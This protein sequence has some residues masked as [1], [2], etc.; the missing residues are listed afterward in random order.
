MNLASVQNRY[1]RKNPV[2]TSLKRALLG[3]ALVMTIV[4]SAF[5]QATEKAC[6][7]VPRD[8]ERMLPPWQHG[9]NNDAVKRGLE[10]T[11]PQV[12]VLADFHGDPTTPKLVLYVGGNYYFAMAPLVKAFEKQNPQYRG[13]LY[14]ETIPPGLLVEQIKAGGTITVG[15]MTWTVKGDAYFA[16]L[17]KVEALIKVGTLVG[18][19]I[20][21]VT[22]TLT[23]MVPKSNPANVKSLAD[24]AQPQ[25]RLAMPDPKFEGIVRQIRL[26]LVKAG[27]EALADA[28]YGTKVKDGSTTLTRIHHRQTPL[29]LMQGLAQAGVTWQSEAMFQEQAG[30]PIGHVEIPAKE[31]ATAIYAGAMVKGAAHPEAAKA[32]LAFIRSREALEIFERYGFKPYKGAG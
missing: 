26:S 30:Y 3:A 19:A 5:A 32:W 17:A 22:N 23:I 31:N 14:W 29:F 8:L 20:P 24:L 25:I 27:G 18:P 6:A 9:E 7:A 16:G 28:V 21:Y 13:K 11:V 10:F 4:N 2:M 15:N 12:D 1:G